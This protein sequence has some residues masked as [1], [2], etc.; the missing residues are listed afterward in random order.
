[1]SIVLR[2]RKIPLA[3]VRDAATAVYD[4]A[5]RTRPLRQIGDGQEMMLVRFIL[6]FLGIHGGQLE[7]LQKQDCK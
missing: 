6:W 1:M 4:A 3:A 7:S 5:V 2:S